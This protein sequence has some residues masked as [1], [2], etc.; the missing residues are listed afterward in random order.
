MFAIRRVWNPTQNNACQSFTF[1]LSKSCFKK[2]CSAQK[3]TGRRLF[4]TR[5][6]IVFET[7][8]IAPYFKALIPHKQNKKV[9]FNSKTGNH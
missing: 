6:F 4:T 8:S 3:K 2:P 1:E 9:C 5:V 7:Y